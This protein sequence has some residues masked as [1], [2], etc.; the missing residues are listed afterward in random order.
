VTKQVLVTIASGAERVRQAQTLDSS[1][2]PLS[3]GSR[4][5]DAT[6]F[7]IAKRR[8][9]TAKVGGHMKTIK[10]ALVCAYALFL[11]F[12]VLGN[13]AM[14][15]LG[16]GAV[17]TAVGMQT[18]FQHPGVM[19]RAISNPAFIWMIFGAIVLAESLCAILC[20]AGATRMW[21]TRSDA[22]AFRSAK[23]TALLGLGLAALLY[24]VGWLAIANE[25]F[26]MW[27]SQKLNVLADAFRNF[28]A[29]I[30]IMLWVNTIEE[31]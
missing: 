8:L 29:A 11:T 3:Q 17:Q 24:F 10:V 1:G 21:K 5:A 30:L 6:G 26:E 9:I 15:D 31:P 4:R 7:S 2:T 14:S 19:W 22:V 12:A 20:W 16:F 27:Q 28:G 13:L 25:W 23:S 18:T